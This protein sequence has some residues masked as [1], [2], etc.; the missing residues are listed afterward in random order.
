M[1]KVNTHFHHFITGE[2]SAAGLARIDQETTR[3]AAEIQENLW[4]HAIGKAQVRGGT[5]YLATLPA[6]TR[7]LPFV[8]EVD[9]VAI[10]ALSN[11]ALRVV[12]DDTIIT[13]AAVTSTVTNGDFSS[14]TGWTLTVGDGAH[15]AI[16]GG[17]LTMDADARGSE[18]S[19]ERS[20]T[21][22][23]TGTEH[24]LEII[25]DRGPVSFRCGSA[26]G[27]EDY[28][29]ETVLDTGHHSLAFTPSVSP[30][31]VRFITRNQRDSIVDS[32][33]VAS[34]GAMVLTSPWTGAQ[35]RDVRFDQS[36]DVVYLANRNWQQRKIER[37]GTR[38][39]SL[40]KYESDD[41]PFRSS[42]GTQ[43]K[44][45]PT[46]TFGNTTLTSDKP[47]F[48]SSMVGQLV[49]LFH[50]RFDTTVQLAGSNTFTDIWVTRG[51]KDTGSNFNDRR[52]DYQT[53]GTWV[54]T[55]TMQR[56]LTGP[57]GDFLD[58]NRD[59]GSTS[60]TFTTNQVVTHA[61]DT[62]NNNIISYNRLGF[63]KDGDYTS[64]TITLFI[65]YE[66]YSGYGVGRITGFTSSTQVDVEVLENFNADS[67]TRSWEVGSW[68]D[69]YGWPSAVVLFDGRLW[70][71]GEDDF[72][73]SASDNFTSFD[74][75]EDGDGA[76]IERKIATGGQVSRVNWFLPLQRLIV[77]TTGAEVSLRS[78]SID[79]RST[80]T[81][82]TLK[83]ASTIGS[84]SVSPVKMDSRGFF[85]DRSGSAVYAIAYSF[86][87]NDYETY[88][89]TY[90]NELICSEG[91]VE[92]AVQRRPESYVWCVR[93]DGEVALLIYDVK[94]KVQGWH[95]FITDGI[96]E[97]VCT[98]PGE[99][100]DQVYLAVQR[101]INSST[102]RYL[103]K[104]VMHS[105]ALGGS[106]NKMA[107]CGSLTA[108]PTT[109]VTVAHLANETDLV[110][111][112]TKD[113]T[114]QVILDLS[115]DGSG[116]V[117]LGDSY[118]NVWVGKGY[119]WRYRSAKLAYGSEGGTAL[120]QRKRISSLGLLLANTH[121]DAITFG[122][123][124][125]TMRNMD[126]VYQ[127]VEIEEHTVWET[128]D[129]IAQGGM[130]G[131]E[132]STDAR[133]HLAGSAPYPATLLGLVMGIET[134]EK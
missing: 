121:M 50:E 28:I 74:D 32:I 61:D 79:E 69:R 132:W 4:P 108:G 128:F 10:L 45:T 39:W 134:N 27:L 76:T 103:E 7:L 49:R 104:V 43:I 47:V 100:E 82:L 106:T 123:D 19:C 51:I 118:S 41:G 60:T 58:F 66:G 114:P 97:S 86:D 64:G 9:D 40:V 78:S 63:A 65:Q 34:A 131:N 37:R 31:Y 53:T 17:K 12:V 109:S 68:S 113:G 93:G 133:L 18:A 46:T 90:F 120:L 111:W 33:Q 26:S 83:D 55:M 1:G 44:V 16:S 38:S 30:Y 36:A 119:D 22:S 57:D 117:A 96:V 24:A 29:T 122:H 72:W 102:V 23:S 112:G 105:E 94:Q 48:T 126:R 130:P 62:Q 77:G 95:K 107:D 116:V 71:G 99:D 54:G 81:N 85:V 3:L 15:G 67:G 89:L 88:D 115:A 70:W 98:V 80:P 84:A 73:G 91:I 129:T 25:V 127:G 92:L 110:G 101:T 52:F 14:G 13:R 8:R 59:E 20:V 6:Q 56:S 124:F 125:D 87:V 11:A 35:L 2:Y 75:L 21:T 42:P 5:E